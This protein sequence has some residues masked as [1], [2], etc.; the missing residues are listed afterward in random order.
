MVDD[1]LERG[2]PVVEGWN[3]GQHHRARF[4]GLEHQAQD[5]ASGRL[6]YDVTPS[7]TL[8]YTFGLF[9]NDDDATANSYLRTAA[10]APAYSGA[11]NINGRAYNIPASAFSNGVYRF[12]ELQLAQGLSQARGLGSAKDGR[13]RALG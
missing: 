8:A 2:R 7:V 5:H 13:K 9:A 11:L 6:T 10:G 4:G 12:D 3:R 1:V